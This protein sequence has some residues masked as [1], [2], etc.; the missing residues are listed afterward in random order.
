[1]LPDPQDAEQ[2]SKWL[3]EAKAFREAFWNALG[4]KRDPAIVFE[5]PGESTIPTSCFV[6][7]PG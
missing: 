4:E 7:A 3:S 2:F 5:H 6:C 1:M